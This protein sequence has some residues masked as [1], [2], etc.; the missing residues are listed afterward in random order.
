[1]AAGTLLAREVEIYRGRTV[2]SAALRETAR[3]VLPGGNNRSS[4]FLQPYPVYVTEGSGCR[5]TDLDG[6]TYVDFGNNYTAVILGRAHPAVVAALTAQA[7][8]GA[9]FAAPTAAEVDAFL[10]AF[11]EIC[12][13]LAKG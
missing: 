1:M 4:I 9:S 13:L 8:R 2:R 5:V 3:K 10:A 11:R 7:R 6:N 12:A